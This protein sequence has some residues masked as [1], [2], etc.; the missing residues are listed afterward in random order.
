MS[1]LYLAQQSDHQQLEWL[2][3][4]VISVLLDS[5]ATNGQLTMQR[6]S[7]E[8][9]E[10][11]PLHKHLYEDEIFMLISGEASVWY[12]G[13]RSEL[14]EGGVVFLPRNVPHCYRIT[15]ERADLLILATPAGMEGMF[16]EIGHDLSLPRPEGLEIKPDPEV[17]ERYGNEVLG[18][19]PFAD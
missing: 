2:E 18:P 8:R 4:S 16:R 6:Q 17:S 14:G 10:A 11:P 7:A 13:Q 12:D 15:S 9:G 3:G 19:P 1:G 5:A